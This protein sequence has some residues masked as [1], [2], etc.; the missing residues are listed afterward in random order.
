[1]YF[2][3][4]SDCLTTGLVNACKDL[5]Q[6]WKVDGRIVMENMYCLQCEYIISSFPS[7]LYPITSFRTRHKSSYTRARLTYDM[8]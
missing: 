8:E 1:M 5:L 7:F 6:V 4:R 3:E 2:G